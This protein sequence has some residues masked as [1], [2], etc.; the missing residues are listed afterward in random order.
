MKVLYLFVDMYLQ[1]FSIYW[2]M[3]DTFVDGHKRS[4]EVHILFSK[5]IQG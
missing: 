2:F 4:I 3:Y 1:K 5:H